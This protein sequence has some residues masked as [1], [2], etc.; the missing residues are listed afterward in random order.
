MIGHKA[1][2]QKKQNAVPLTPFTK[3]EKSAMPIRNI[4]FPDDYTFSKSA[5]RADILFSGKPTRGLLLPVL[6]DEQG[7][8]RALL[9]IQTPTSFQCVHRP[10]CPWSSKISQ[11]GIEKQLSFS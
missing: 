11:V 7:T 8:V 10:L 1:E 4:S 5:H 2:T 9:S 6:L 3:P